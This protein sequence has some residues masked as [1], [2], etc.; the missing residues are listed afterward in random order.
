MDNPY[1]HLPELPTFELTSTDISDGG[2]LPNA[3]LSGIF[4]AGGEDVSPQLSWS[5]FPTETKSFVV[6]CYDPEAPT[7]SGFWH[8]AVVDIPASVTSL[9]TGVG[10]ESGANLPAGAFQLRND[11]GL[12]RYGF[13][14]EALQVLSGLFDASV[15]MDL[16]R[17]PELFCGLPRRSGERP[18]L[19]PV[20]CNPQAWAAGAVFSL[21]QSAL[22][23]DVDG[24]HATLR[25]TRA[26]LPPFL[27]EVYIRRLRVG[28]ARLDLRFQRH[29]HDVGISVLRRDGDAEVVAI[30]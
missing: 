15:A 19:Y 6:T 28:A 24:P 21:L 13:R 16:H 3:Q 22:G 9:P 25:L 5:G 8:W 30:K 1:D 4:G 26:L 29:E 18:T 14:R 10:D 20:A 11:A 17:L 7:A 27:D 2:E 12:R 23:L